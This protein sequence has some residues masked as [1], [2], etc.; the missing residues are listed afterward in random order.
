MSSDTDRSVSRAPRGRYAPSPTGELHVG[1]AATALAAWLSVRSRGGS[2]VMRVEDLDR[3][4]VRDGLTERILGDLS[5][6]GLD[7]DEGPDRG[8]PHEPYEQWPRRRC[9]TAAFERLERAGQ[10]YPCFCSRRDIAAA[11]SA[12]QEPGD[13]LRYPGTCRGLDPAEA[14]ERAAAGARHAWRFRVGPDD[15]PSFVDLVHGRRESP[16]PPGDFVVYR[17]DG[18]P[19]YQLAVVVDDA[20]MR[21]DEVVRGDDLLPST[22]RQLLLYDALALTPPSFA[23]VPL[24]LGTDGVRL[25]KRHR[26]V[27][28]AELR[29]AGLDRERIIGRLAW[30]LGLRTEP[31]PRPAAALV[32]TFDWSQV[33]RAPNGVVIDPAGW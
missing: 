20:E 26:G 8:G 6:L 7:W 4:R 3:N 15:R 5:W 27:T 33:V 17:A 31:A 11:A 28:I 13:E 29:E 19:A 2:L 32:E 14:E 12:P 21:I 9:Y 30:V 16:A 22:A 24:L 23:H 10:V 18:V 25:S 1:N